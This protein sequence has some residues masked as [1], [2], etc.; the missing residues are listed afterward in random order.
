[1]RKTLIMCLL[2][3][4][5]TVPV[6]QNGEKKTGTLCLMVNGFKNNDGKTM[7]ALTN[8][9]ENYENANVLP[10][11]TMKAEIKNRETVCIFKN[12]PFGIYAV[13]VFHDENNN[14]K[15]D[16]NFLGIPQEAY[17]FSNN[18]TGSFGPAS[19]EDARFEMNGDSLAISVIVK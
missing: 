8:S 3:T 11:R 16:T 14:D 4:I 12:I 9:K 17:G 18:A 2:L 1:M 13:K 19:W 7:I 6:A 5:F 10:F 15:L